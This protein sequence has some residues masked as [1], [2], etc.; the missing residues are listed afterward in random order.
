MR[1]PSACC[2]AASVAGALNTVS[3]V[4]SGTAGA[5]D[6]EG[7]LSMLVR[8]LE[9]DLEG[10]EAELREM[11]CPPCGAVELQRLARL[12]EL[13]TEDEVE[14][15]GLAEETDQDTWSTSFETL[16]KQETGAVQ[17]VGEWIRDKDR[18]EG[19][20]VRLLGIPCVGGI[21]PLHMHPL[22]R[23]RRWTSWSCDGHR[24]C[25]SE[26]ASAGVGPRFRCSKGCDFDVCLS[27]FADGLGVEAPAV[28]PRTAGNW[29]GK[30]GTVLRKTKAIRLLRQDKPQTALIGNLD[31]VEAINTQTHR[32]ENPDAGTK[33]M[34]AMLLMGKGPNSRPSSSITASDACASAMRG[35]CPLFVVSEDDPDEIIRAQWEA[36]KTCVA[37]A[38]SLTSNTMPLASGKSN[39]TR[40]AQNPVN[41]AVISH[42]S[43]HYALLFAVREA[44]NS[45]ASAGREMLTNKGGQK[46]TTWRSFK[47]ARRSMLTW[48]GYKMILVIRASAQ[49]RD[50]F[51]RNLLANF[52]SSNSTSR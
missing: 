8:K 41:T 48:A 30:L 20:S 29:R 17:G 3:G 24:A 39:S 25:G 9:A 49:D 28:P 5:F 23:S 27:C 42:H 2:G 34:Y 10:V 45:D 40:P 36:L 22:R 52:N 13:A 4:K 38:D 1:Q 21:R 51:V 33:G 14:E 15:K 47:A 11:G 31:I 12:M 7:G 44:N 6:L 43:N 16:M 50:S 46:P 19:E 32:P 18:E 37:A 26:T 35:E